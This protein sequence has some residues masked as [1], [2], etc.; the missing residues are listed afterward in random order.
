MNSS[1][2]QVRRQGMVITPDKKRVLL[3]PFVPV[4]G[5]AERTRRI[6]RQIMKLSDA[7]ARRVFEGVLGEFRNRHRDAEGFF[8]RR[9]DQLKSLLPSKF[10]PLKTKRLLIGS[11]FTCEYSLEAAALFNPSIIPHPDQS[12]LETGSIRFIM[13]LRATG[14]GHIS[15]IEFRTGTINK[16]GEVTVDSPS[17]FVSSAEERPDPVY[18][19]SEFTM[20]LHDEGALTSATKEILR[21]LS[22]KF[23]RSQLVTQ[24]ARFRK[25][26][27]KLTSVQ[28]RSIEQAATWVDPNYTIRFS[29][30][31]ELSERVIFPVSSYERNG[32]ED[33]RFVRFTD[34]DGTFTY[35]STYTAY[36]G[37]EIRPQLIQTTDFTH[38]R[39]RSLSGDAATN[40][41]MALFPRRIGGKFAM[42]TRQ[43]GES[44]YMA[45]SDDVS[46]WIKPVKLLIPTRAWEF[47]QIGNCGSPVET[48]KGW[49]LLTHGVGPVRKYCIGAVLLD[50][51]NPVKVIGQ[52]P[53]PLIAPDESE[54]EGYVPNVVY[55]CGAILHN[56]TLIIP[57]AMSDTS[58]RIASVGI[59]ELLGRMQ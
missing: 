8:R 19:K 21:P 11:Y 46:R 16:L 58:T 52:L 51:D 50:R 29:K 4:P 2:L 43:D 6:V 27:G 57:Y 40:K 20:K 18:E 45:L 3:R 7:E 41:G 9:F 28:S 15:S 38:F 42:I 30:T 24:I 56:R 47:T 5:G 25:S 37:K 13:S 26:H 36:N 34:E 23:R 54:R 10:K 53:E 33:A 49:L 17:R 12:E 31:R 14:E 59:D 39:I 44:L 55:T 48:D 1:E 22:K 32:I 35:Y